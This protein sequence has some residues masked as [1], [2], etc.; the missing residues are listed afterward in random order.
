MQFRKVMKEIRRKHGSHIT[1]DYFSGWTE[2]ELW[3]FFDAQAEEEKARQEEEKAR[4]EEEKAKEKREKRREA[5]T[6]EM[7]RRIL[8]KKEKVALA[9]ETNNA[10]EAIEAR[11]GKDRERYWKLKKD[12]EQGSKD[13]S[14]SAVRREAQQ[15]A[16]DKLIQTEGQKWGDPDAS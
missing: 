11:S 4:Q 3:I 6:R 15:A 9:Q 13:E 5:A 8:A 7:E 16:L 10:L 1:L 14:F 2:K 12:L